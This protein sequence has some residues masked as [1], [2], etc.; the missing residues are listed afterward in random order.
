MAAGVKN[1]IVS[2]EG[3]VYQKDLGLNTLEISRA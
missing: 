2:Y 3:I 1:F